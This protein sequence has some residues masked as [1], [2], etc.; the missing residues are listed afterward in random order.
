VRVWLARPDAVE[1]IGGLPSGVEVDAWDGAS[2]PPDTLLE[3]EFYVV[4]F[5]PRA[6]IALEVLPTLPKLAVVQVPV[7]GYEDV[8]GLLRDDVTL[9]NARGI[10]DATTAEWVVAAI[11]AMIRDFPA[12]VREQA[13]GVPRR[14]RGDGLVGK[15]VLIVGY[16]S[17]GKAIERRL[18]GFEVEIV[19]VARHAR[20]GV[21]PS[22]AL[23][24]LLGDAD[25][26]VL[27]VPGSPDT[28][29]LVDA[30][31]LARMRDGALLVNAARGSVVDQDALTSELA[32]G[33]LRAALDVAEPDPL[34]A[35]HPLLA[36]P[37]LFY[38]PH[39]AGDTRLDVPMAYSFIGQQLRRFVAGDALANVVAR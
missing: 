17:I 21:H 2:T 9:C 13:A 32:S 1:L 11:L 7:A 18:Q 26:V 27:Q 16:G 37:A 20:D 19:R 34:P 6:E 14:R 10:H 30:E 15:R 4:P 39:Q 28:R 22:E 5:K 23:P 38:T 25:I 31:F 8:I 35:G 33:R 3:V 36:L 12:F 29:H 24:A